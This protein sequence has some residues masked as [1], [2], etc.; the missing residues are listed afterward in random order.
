MKYRDNQT[1][2]MHEVVVP[3]SDQQD[4]EKTVEELKYFDPDHITVVYVV[5]G[6][7]Q[8]PKDI[9]LDTGDELHEIVQDEFEE[10]DFELVESDDIVSSIV[11]LAVDKDATSIVFRPSETSRISTVF[12]QSKNLK[13]ITHSSVPVLALPEPEDME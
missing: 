8:T 10:A 6:N 3:V 12:S 7:E 5:Q 2:V 9:H 11:D 13:L 4:T 1:D